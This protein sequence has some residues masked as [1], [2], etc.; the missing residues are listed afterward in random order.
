[1]GGSPERHR[2]T[3]EREEPHNP[4][5]HLRFRVTP[6]AGSGSLLDDSVWAIRR[7]RVG[8][9]AMT[10]EDEETEELLLIRGRPPGFQKG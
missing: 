8:D 4:R 9:Q 6:I 1:M 3:A 7:L 10:P 2:P 5:V